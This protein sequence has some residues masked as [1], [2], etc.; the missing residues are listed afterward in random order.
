MYERLE[1]YF[2]DVFQYNY[3]LRSV[4][5]NLIYV[6]QYESDVTWLLSVT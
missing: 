4:V 3:L 5:S 6:S 2:K 1:G